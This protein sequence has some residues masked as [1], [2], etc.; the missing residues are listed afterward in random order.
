MF[1]LYRKKVK[2]IVCNDYT[3]IGHDDGQKWEKKDY[4]HSENISAHQFLVECANDVKLKCFAADSLDLPTS[5]HAVVCSGHATTLNAYDSIP[6]DQVKWIEASKELYTLR[7]SS[8][9]VWT[10]EL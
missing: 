10:L 6:D 5:R 3:W 4:S 9:K 2:Y 8:P 7:S 1:D